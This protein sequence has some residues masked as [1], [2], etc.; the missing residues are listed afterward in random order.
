MK[1]LVALAT[2]LLCSGCEGGDSLPLLE[3]SEAD[4]G[5]TVSARVGQEI[6]V[7]LRGNPTTGYSWERPA[8]EGA[9]VQAL[10]EVEYAADPNP[11]GLVGV[12][13]TFRARYRAAQPGRAVL[14]LRYRR[15][16]EPESS[17]AARFE[18]TVNVVND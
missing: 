15:P 9:A 4:N 16:W 5:K 6:V 1:K 2:W 7:S 17:V 14:R 18:V 10:G 12:G 11:A 13:G 3:L 8:P